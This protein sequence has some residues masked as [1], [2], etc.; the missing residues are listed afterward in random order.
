MA[1][2][3]P[4][5]TSRSEVASKARAQT[6]SRCP[7]SPRKVCSSWLLWSDD[8]ILTSLS[9]D[10]VANRIDVASCWTARTHDAWAATDES[11][12]DETTSYALTCVSSHAVRST[13]PSGSNESERTGSAWPSS[14]REVLLATSNTNTT[15]ECVPAAMKSPMVTSVV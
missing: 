6:W 3:S 14:L 2:S 4:T 5:E 9:D 7:E 1:A 13:P 15:P 12:P 11:M 10:A 8:Q